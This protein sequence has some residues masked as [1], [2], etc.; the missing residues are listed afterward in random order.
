[1]SEQAE[2]L[3]AEVIHKQL[4]VEELRDELAREE[5]L[6]Q[7]LRLQS[8]GIPTPTCPD[9]SWDHLAHL[10]SQGLTLKQIARKLDISVNVATYNA[11]K[12]A[13]RGRYPLPL[14]SPDDDET[15]LRN[16][17]LRVWNWQNVQ[18]L[19]DISRE[20]ALPIETIEPQFNW[21]VEQKH[22]TN[23]RPSAQ[24]PPTV[25]RP[26]AQ[27]SNDVAAP[28]VATAPLPTSPEQEGTVED[29]DDEDDKPSEK[30][31][32]SEELKAEV[33]RQQGN[34]KQKNAELLTT[35]QKK[36]RHQ[37]SV[38]FFGDG[39]T[40]PDSSGHAHRVKAFCLLPAHSHSHEFIRP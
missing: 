16:H 37:T 14:R 22:I 40:L 36:H 35:C 1:M 12:L 9:D 11:Y 26:P 30:I 7:T 34:Q 39:H 10:R 24:T 18:D 3:K 19:P 20:L 2:N 27:V 38:D 29:L 28:E 4:R 33:R 13:R 6:L 17:I 8:M 21:L 25:S 5:K 15:V 23:W 31:A 32:T